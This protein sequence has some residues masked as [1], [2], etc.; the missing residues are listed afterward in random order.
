ML[1]ACASKISEVSPVGPDTYLVRGF[2]TE[3]AARGANEHCAKLQKK[4]LVTN[5]T[6][7]TSESRATFIFRCLNEDDPEYRRP[8]FERSPDTVIRDD[9]K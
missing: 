2:N 9:R 3:D 4:L 6:P 8:T 1:G 5:I 7:S